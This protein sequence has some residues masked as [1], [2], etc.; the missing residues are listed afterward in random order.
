MKTT[1]F[2]ITAHAA[3]TSSSV[4]REPIDRAYLLDTDLHKNVSLTS[5]C[6]FIT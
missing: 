3:N 6:L 5:V 2:L 4:E 1:V